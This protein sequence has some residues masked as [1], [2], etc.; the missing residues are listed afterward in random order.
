MASGSMKPRQSRSPSSWQARV[1]VRASSDEVR[2]PADDLV[3]A[4][5]LDPHFSRAGRMSRL[6]ALLGQQIQ[7]AGV[8]AGDGGQRLVQPWARVE[9]ISPMVTRREVNCSCSCQAGGPVPR[10]VCVR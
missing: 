8:V 1:W 5:R 4:L 9:A 6:P 10:R 3:G 2:H 7:A